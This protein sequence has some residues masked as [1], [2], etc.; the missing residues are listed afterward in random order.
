MR[1][2]PPSTTW[3]YTAI[4][5]VQASALKPFTKSSLMR[6]RDAR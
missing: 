5:A 2:T 4:A 6:Y 1:T 3:P